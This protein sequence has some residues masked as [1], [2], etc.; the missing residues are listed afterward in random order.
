MTDGG[1]PGAMRPGEELDADALRAFLERE[2]WWGGEPLEIRQYPR[3]FS[4]LTYQLTTGNRTY[5]LRRPPAGVGK[6]TAHDVLR[7]GRIMRALAPVFP[8][9]PRV[10]ALCEDESVVG[11]PF[12]LMERVEGVILREPSRH[13]WAAD[14]DSMA[15]ASAATVD[16]LAAIHA[17]D[18]SSPPVAALG[19]PEGYVERQVA[20]WTRRYASARTDAHA[21]VEATAEWLAA[22]QPTESGHA[23]VHNDFKYDNLVFDPGDPGR[24]RAVLDWEMATLGDPLLDL[25]TTL[26]YW[27]EPDDDAGIRELG[28]GLTARAGNLTRR[29]VVARYAAQTGRDTGAVVWY[30]AFGLFKVAVIAQQ[31][32]ARWR[33]GATADP[34]FAR[35]DGAVAAIGVA[36]QRAIRTGRLGA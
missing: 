2:G 1:A 3:G 15:R 27:V 10:H 22:H 7:E 23:V 26:A 28:I 16:V 14:P 5:V 33:Q 13:P 8:S 34:R 11:A 19:R 24:V 4:N 6:G 9:I 30:F 20:G 36:A 18:V 17:I 29:G 25:G 12:C 35:L 32:H 31:L 21:D